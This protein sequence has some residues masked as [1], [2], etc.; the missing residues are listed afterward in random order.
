MT[1]HH[2]AA[3]A[4]T[5]SPGAAPSPPTD[6]LDIDLR[7]FGGY[8]LHSWWIILLFIVLGVVVSVAAARLT[9]SDY[10]ASS[11]VYVG[12]ATDATGSSIASVSSNPKAPASMATSSSVLHEVAAETGVKLAAL[13]RAISVEIPTPTA[14][15]SGQ[16]VNF[17]TI[18]VR[19]QDATKAAKVVNAVARA[20]R[21][22]L[23]V[24]PRRKIDFLRRRVAA[25]TRQ[26][27]GLDARSKA[28]ER[29]LR[30]IATSAGSA[31]QRAMAST[32]FVALQQS[33]ASQRAVVAN[34]LQSAKLQLLT[35]QNVEMPRIISAAA[36]PA[37][38]EAMDVR[39]AAGIGALAGAVIGIVVAVLRGRR[40]ASSADPA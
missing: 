16:I 3:R 40:R 19:Y 20:V 26:I 15:T 9:A 2:S 30:R 31:E 17:I 32:P 29:E 13:Q 39:V 18:K 33:I 6:D 37:K 24:F 35:S 1:E 11:S 23:A 7:R 12:Q 4:E 8:L 5:P 10:V 14:R 36:I 38:R 27:S 28:V 34:E 25:D 22:R 21:N